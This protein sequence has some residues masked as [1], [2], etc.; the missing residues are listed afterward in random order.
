M[1]HLKLALTVVNVVICDIADDMVPLSF[2][3]TAT[4]D[5]ILLK[6]TAVFIVI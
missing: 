4:N 6:E 5:Q 1:K 3:R 2:K